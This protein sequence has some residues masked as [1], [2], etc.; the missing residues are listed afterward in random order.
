MF[1][2]YLW[3]GDPEQAI[4][5]V[6]GQVFYHNVGEMAKRDQRRRGWRFAA[7]LSTALKAAEVL[8]RRGIVMYVGA[9]WL[10][11]HESLLYVSLRRRPSEIRARQNA[12][13]VHPRAE[14]LDR[15][16]VLVTTRATR[17]S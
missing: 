11:R 16:R 15:V 3:A 12:D 1:Q 7:S 14:A 6:E 10:H 13:H 9:L 2:Y 4:R 5:C 17:P 8:R